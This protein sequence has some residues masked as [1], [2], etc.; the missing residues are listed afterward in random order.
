VKGRSASSVSLTKRIGAPVAILAKALT[1]LQTEAIIMPAPKP[2]DDHA[3]GD[4]IAMKFLERTQK[5]ENRL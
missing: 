4:P 5:A 2:A 3:S 1:R